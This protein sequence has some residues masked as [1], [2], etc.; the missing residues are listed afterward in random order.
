MITGR[1]DELVQTGRVEGLK[2]PEKGGQGVGCPRCNVSSVRL[3]TRLSNLHV[4]LLTRPP[5]IF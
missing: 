3:S 5:R 4:E 2:F 1:V